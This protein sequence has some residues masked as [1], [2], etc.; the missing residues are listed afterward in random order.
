LT[1]PFANDWSLTK[2][3]VDNINRMAKEIA[4]DID[5]KVLK[6]LIDNEFSRSTRN[7]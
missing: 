3:G 6:K 7:N 4:E 2:N 5:A 1:F